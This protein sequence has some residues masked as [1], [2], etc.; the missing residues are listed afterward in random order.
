MTKWNLRIRFAIFL[1]TQHLSFF[2]YMSLVNQSQT[3]FVAL[4]TLFV[5]TICLNC[6]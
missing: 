6:F 1:S 5:V 3:I 2:C 4:Q